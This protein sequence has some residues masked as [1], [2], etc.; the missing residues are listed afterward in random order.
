MNI[1]TTEI[2]KKKEEWKEEYETH[3]TDD[4]SP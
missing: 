2:G 1:R 4:K 3:I